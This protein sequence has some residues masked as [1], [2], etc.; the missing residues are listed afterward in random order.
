[1]K[2]RGGIHSI[3]A[4]AT[5]SINIVVDDINVEATREESSKSSRLSNQ[6]T[7]TKK[8]KEWREHDEMENN[9]RET[10]RKE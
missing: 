2:E 6:P 1:M 9:G 3:I 7:K 10:K 8:A 4:Y 5:T